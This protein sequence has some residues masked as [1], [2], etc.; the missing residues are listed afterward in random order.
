MESQGNLSGRTASV[1]QPPK[2]PL[3]E[4]L[5]LYVGTVIG[6]IFSSA[7]TH[8][9]SG[10]KMNLNL[11]LTT[12]VISCVVAL[13]IIPQIYERLNVPPDTPLLI[14]FG[15][16]VQHGVFWHVLFSSLGKVIAR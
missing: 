14:R 3:W 12:V 1:T 11:D 5:L 8:F 4:Q 16:F 10:E 7:A 6:V 13:V 9:K 2:M 15:L